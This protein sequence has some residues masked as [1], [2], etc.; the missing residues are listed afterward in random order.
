MPGADKENLFENLEFLKLA[1]IAFYHDLYTF[2]LR[3]VLKEGIRIHSPFG[4]KWL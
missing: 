2:D 3:V 4:V 1:I